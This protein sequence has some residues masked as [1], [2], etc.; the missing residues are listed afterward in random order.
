MPGPESY[1]SPV[2][3]VPT[4]DGDLQRIVLTG[5]MGSGK[6]T[7]GRLL[8]ARLGWRFADLD[9]EVEARTGRSVPQIF[10]EDGEPAFR[11]AEADALAAL[12]QDSRIVIALGGGAPG[13]PAVRER[14]ASV[15]QTAVVH[16]DAPFPLLYDRC[17]AQA[18]DP[19]AT[20]RPL[21]GQRHAAA[22]RYE[23]R[24]AIYTAVA[25]YRVHAG[26]G[27]PEAI[28]GAVL[29]AVGMDPLSET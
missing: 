3:P 2:N 17:A 25:H 12:L 16:L 6:T 13:T 10:A 4:P 14:L 19:E 21:L 29:R 8:A 15:T 5:F 22:E 1:T 28:A 23:A 18:L 9:D 24:M 20:T 26:S 11:A 27:P 7:V